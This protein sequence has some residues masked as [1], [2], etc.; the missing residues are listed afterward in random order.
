MNLFNYLM[1][2]TQSIRKVNY[3]D[4]QALHKKT[5]NG[6][7]INTLSADVQ[8]CLI[9]GTIQINQEEK[10]INELI[11][12]NPDIYVVVYGK[13][14]NDE[15]IYKKYK[16]L[17]DLGFSNV[18]L[19]IGGLFEWLLLQDIYGNDDFKTTNDELDILKYK[20][21]SSLSNA[22]APF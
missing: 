6:L 5:I 13:N 14:S 10:I 15:S 17:S 11:T 8:S 3:E 21:Q 12:S 18:R 16:Q 4:V 19:Y 7:L 22:L 9:N 2:N 1:G 20:P